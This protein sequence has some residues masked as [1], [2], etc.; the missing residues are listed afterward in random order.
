MCGVPDRFLQAAFDKDLQKQA[1][2]AAFAQ[3]GDNVG[4]EG[5]FAQF[6]GA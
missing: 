3:C 4:E 6:V 1:T 5:K 2:K